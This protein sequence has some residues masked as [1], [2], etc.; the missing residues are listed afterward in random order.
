MDDTAAPE[1]ECG[2]PLRSAFTAEIEGL[3]ERIRVLTAEI[4][5]GKRERQGA[6]AGGIPESG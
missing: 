5:A 4:E 2:D 1:Q 3:V 6:A